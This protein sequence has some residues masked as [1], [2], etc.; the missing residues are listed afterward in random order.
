MIIRVAA[1][2]IRRNGDLLITRRPLNVHLAGLWEFPGGK[3]EGDESLEEA[4]VREIKEELAVRIEVL[5][6]FYSVEHH[7]PRRSVQLHFFN[8]RIVEGEPRC[9]HVADFRWI[10]PSEFDQYHF[11][12]ADQDL[13]M[14]LRQE[15]R[16]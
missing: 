6:E 7:Y 9:V 12:E 10:M 16:D 8:C 13:I 2:I 14:R 4:L 3:V 11:P 5:E 15:P 1:A